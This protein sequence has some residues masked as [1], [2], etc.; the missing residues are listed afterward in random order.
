MLDCEDIFPSKIAYDRPSSKLINFLKKHYNLSIFIPQN[1]NFVIYKEYFEVFLN[2][3][4]IF[5]SVL[6]II[7][8]LFL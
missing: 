3:L 1:N 2:F 4:K 6:F 7:F 5:I 8:L